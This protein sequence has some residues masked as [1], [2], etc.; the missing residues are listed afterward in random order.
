MSHIDVDLPKNTKFLVTGG[1]GFI[2]ANLVEK[3]LE[4]GCWVRVIDDFSTGKESNIG[5]F[6]KLDNFELIEGDIRNLNTCNKACQNI[7][8][9]L[10][11]AALGSVPRSIKYPESTNEVNI[12]G[13]LNM[14]IA[15]KENNIQRFIYASSSS[16][17][18]DEE[19]LPKIEEKIGKPLSPYAVSKY[20]N[21]LYAYNF[22]K[23]YG[24]ETIG[25]RYFN[26]YGRKQD[27]NSIYAAV[28]PNF[29]SK[30]LKNDRPIIYGDGT[31]SRDFTY[32]DDVIQA[33]IK[34]CIAKK[35]VSGEVFN[36]ANGKKTTIN[37]L[38]DIICDLL[39]IEVDPIYESA[40]KGDVKHSLADISKAVNLLDY[41]PKFEIIEGLRNC[42]EWYQEN[43]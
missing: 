28:I 35:E 31:Q 22:Y 3:L 20:T 27:P 11:Q 14:L 39:N 15:A 23:I 19:T 26:V 32:I 21:E 30:L 37:S 1:A 29:I 34:A 2:G 17:Y 10:H 18:G 13:T 25:L 40:R 6:N 41:N 36:I 43:L 24:L 4:I 7:D 8:Y 33:N 9:V 12:T 16:V 5:E 42:I 38:Y